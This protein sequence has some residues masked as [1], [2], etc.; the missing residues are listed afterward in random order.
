MSVENND[1]AGSADG[2]NDIGAENAFHGELYF[3]TYGD[4]DGYCNDDG[5]QC[6]QGGCGQ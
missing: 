3:N 5:A 1:H 2:Y 6:S 4:V